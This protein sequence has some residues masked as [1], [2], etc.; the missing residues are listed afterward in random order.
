M[1]TV[2]ATISLTKAVARLERLQGSLRNLR[3]NAK[4]AASRATVVGATLGGAYIGGYIDGWGERTEKDLTV[5]DSTVTYTLAGG[6]GA[7]FVGALF[8]PQIGEQAADVLMGL[9][10]GMAA[11]E[12]SKTGRAA[13]I[14]PPE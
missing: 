6:I 7:A 2:P 13:G 8:A 4:I 9:G 1:A 14:K 5:G 3:D 10:S 11:A 12:I